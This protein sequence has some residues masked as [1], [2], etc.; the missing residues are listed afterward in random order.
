MRAS[1]LTIATL[2]EDPAEAEVASHRLL[3]RAGFLHKSG[4]GL[5]LYGPMMH[6]VLDRIQRIVAEEISRPNGAIAA[7]QITMPILQEQALWEKSGRWA[8]YQASRTMLSV[9]DRKDQI[10]GLAPTAEEVVTDYAAAV[11]KSYT[12]LPACF[13]QQHTKFRDEIRPRFGL[14]RVKEFIMMDAYS[15]HADEASL[16]ATYQAMRDAYHRT[17]RRMGLEAFAVEADS[18]AIG[19]SG[20]H[21]FMV[22]AAIGE[23]TILFQPETGYAA[24]R[25]RA[26]GRIAPAPAWNAPSTATLVHTPSVGAILE[27]MAFLNVNGY[28][29]VRAEHALKC[30]LFVARSLTATVQV[31]AFVRGDREIHEVK[32][33]NAITRALGDRGPVLDLRPMQPDEVRAATSAEPG[34]AG[35]GTGL[36]VDLAFI[37]R[38]LPADQP[39]IAGANRTDHHLVGFRLDRDVVIRN[40][41]GGSVTPIVDDLLAIR[42]GDAD[43]ASGKPLSER[44]GIEVGHV[45]KLGT[46]YSAAMQANYM[47][48]DGKLHPYIMGC[49]GIGSSRVAAAAVEQHHD[50]DGIRWPMAIAPYQVVIVPAGKPGDP[51]VGAASQ[52]LHDRLESAGIDVILDDRDLKPGVKF[53]DWDL[54]GIPLRIVIGKG[55]A[56]G[57]VELKPRTGAMAEIPVGEAAERTIAA[58]RAALV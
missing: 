13:F 23:D 21:E 38:Q 52:D 12:Q 7:Q 34:F 40:A 55:L 10:F 57:L 56:N 3:L 4:A 50:A 39:L 29:D 51:A 9:K 42:E 37:D 6:R 15:F 32:L 22:A 33:I 54:I 44:R 1:R 31:A 46:K 43:V 16:D 35:P 30:V 48:Q 19:G 14:M 26:V 24:N 49:Y 28:P 17:F 53:K 45:F 36:T 5:Y 20:S 25:E 41:R 47:G 11:L 18:G 8:T 2:R 27:V 58:V